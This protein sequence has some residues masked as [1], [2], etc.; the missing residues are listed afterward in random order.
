[1]PKNEKNQLLFFEKVSN[2]RCLKRADPR[3]F[4]R[5]HLHHL[6]LRPDLRLFFIST[7]LADLQR[8]RRE[9]C[10]T[11]LLCY[12]VAVQFQKIAKNE[13]AAS[14]LY[15]HYKRE[16]CNFLRHHTTFFP[17]VHGDE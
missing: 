9:R 10:Q 7:S 13:F 17:I 8:T 11:V 15:H 5:L 1:M 3:G 12:L 4:K 6:Y 2:C 14:V 16:F